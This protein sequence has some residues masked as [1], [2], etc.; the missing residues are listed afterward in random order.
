MATT[1]RTPRNY[2]ATEATLINVRAGQ[3]YDFRQDVRLQA[4]V[5]RVTALEAW[6][7][8]MTILHPQVD[9]RVK[10]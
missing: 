1:K 5:R 9:K 10:N 8:R 7:D 2:A 6:A 4:L 3:K